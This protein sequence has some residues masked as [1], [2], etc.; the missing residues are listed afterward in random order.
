M[1][2]PNSANNKRGLFMWLSLE[3]ASSLNTVANWGLLVGLIIGVV[4]TFIMYI[5]GGIKEQ[6]LRAGI[7]KSNERAAEALLE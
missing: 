5:T 7:A 1:T 4:S 2:I 6:Y 3:N